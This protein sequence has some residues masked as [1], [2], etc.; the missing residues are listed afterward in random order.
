M[1]TCC[2]KGIELTFL[3]IS[4]QNNG[5]LPFTSCH[6]FQQP[7]SC[8]EIGHTWKMSDKLTKF[9]SN[10]WDGLAFRKKRIFSGNVTS[11]QQIWSPTSVTNIDFIFL[12]LEFTPGP[13]ISLKMRQFYLAVLLLYFFKKTTCYWFIPYS[14][15]FAVDHTI[16]IFTVVSIYGCV[17]V[18]TILV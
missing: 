6:V 8:S 7:P 10:F 13:D 18:L 9:T 3:P 5:W 14:K 1:I 12:T 15:C 17:F 4:N 11:H 16:K 2:Q